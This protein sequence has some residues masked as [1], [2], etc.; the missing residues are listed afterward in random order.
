MSLQL[1]AASYIHVYTLGFKEK[2]KRAAVVAKASVH[3]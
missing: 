3:K 2:E 1:A